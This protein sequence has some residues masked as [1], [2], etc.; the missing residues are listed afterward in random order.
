VTLSKKGFETAVIDDITIVKGHRI[1]SLGEITLRRTTETS[2][3]LAPAEIRAD[4]KGKVK[5]TVTPSGQKPTGAV[6]VKEGRKTVGSG[7]LKAKHKGELTITL[8]KL[9]KGNHQLT[10]VYGGSG[11]FAGSTSKKLTLT[12]KAPK[13]KSQRPNALVFVG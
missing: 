13:K 4:E 8:D 6:S 3:K 7:T 12:V 5:V 10:V 1:A 2:G 9:A 11:V